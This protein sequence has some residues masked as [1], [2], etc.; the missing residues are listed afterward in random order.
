[1]TTVAVLVPCR[2]EERYIARCLDSLVA[3]DFDLSRLEILV[4]DGMSCDGTREIV[5]EYS[6]RHRHLRRIDNL[7]GDKPS[8]LNLGI[9]SATADI[10]IRVDAHAVY[11]HDYISRLVAGLQETGA[12]NVGGVRETAL[13]ETAWEQAVGI[14][15]SH[16]FA[17]GNALH[18]TGVRNHAMRDVDTVFGGCYRREVFER[19][20]G[21]HPGLL[22]A[23]DRELNARLIEAG[24]RIVL[25][26]DVRCTYFPRTRWWSYTNW[27]F[28]GGFWVY[29]ASR[30]TTTPLRSWR[31]AIPIFFVLWH[32]LLACLPFSGSLLG[33][34]LLGTVLLA[35]L[36]AY[37]VLAF[38]FA[39]SAA[40]EHR[41]AAIF[42]RLV[43]LFAT[44]HFAYGVG[45][46]A[47]I[48]AWK[49]RGRE[50]RVCPAPQI[51][52]ARAA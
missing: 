47:G 51:L 3:N 31:N 14:V 7:A 28:Q 46:I 15:I 8:A 11:P 29:Y 25:I 39:A 17:A 36:A 27:I 12:D 44:T 42:P 22:R 37:W 1:M 6:Q 33:T 48:V 30:F 5:D 21:F 40:W 18:R 35:P 23:Q 45:S 13:G 24:G 34:V 43:I 9:Q 26:P 52:T 19:I 10:V 4:I 2:N 41:S 50:D 16:R 20:G 32:A 49:L 38:L